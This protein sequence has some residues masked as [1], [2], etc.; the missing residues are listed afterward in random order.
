MHQASLEF[1]SSRR[2]HWTSVKDAPV[3]FRAIRLSFDLKTNEPQDR[4]DSLLKLTERHCV[5]FQTINQ[6]PEFSVTA[7]A[8]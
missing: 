5:V 4:I 1:V 2:D 3:G 7:R 6:K 8:G